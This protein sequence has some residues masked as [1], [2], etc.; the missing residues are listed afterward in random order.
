VREGDDAFIGP[1]RADELVVSVV[2]PLAAA[3]EPGSNTAATVFDRY[4]SP[5]PN[6]WTRHML[7]LLQR[8]GHDVPTVRTARAHQGLHHLYH[9]FCRSGRYGRCTVCRMARLTD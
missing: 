3:L 5:P 2:L 6:R 9:A 7:G 8:A 4:P 1:G